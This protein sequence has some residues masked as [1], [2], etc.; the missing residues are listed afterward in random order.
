MNY[1]ISFKERAEMAK[2]ILSAQLPATLTDA[3]KHVITTKEK[4]KQR[5]YGTLMSVSTERIKR[6][7]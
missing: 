7:V 4:S 1:K 6:G 3:K 5:N 2:Q